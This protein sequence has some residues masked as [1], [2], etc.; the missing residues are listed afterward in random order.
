MAF[1]EEYQENPRWTHFSFFA[2]GGTDGAVTE[3]LNPTGKQFILHEIRL[4]FS[5]IFASVEDLVVRLSA[6]KGSAHNVTLISQALSD[7]YDYVWINSTGMHF[8]S[9]DQL[10]FSWSQASGVNIGG[11]NV[12]GWG[13][14]G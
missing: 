5:V 10:V 8:L 7:L 13:V 3:S 12:Q 9:D 11:L 1:T 4:H 14:W 6:A 2:S